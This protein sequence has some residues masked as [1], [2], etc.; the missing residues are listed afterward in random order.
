MDLWREGEYPVDKLF[1]VAAGG[2]S[3]GFQVIDISYRKNKLI[4]NYY[5]VKSFIKKMY[6]KS[7][8]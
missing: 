1:P 2:V 6:R 7:A 4:K 3:Q 5:Q 8:R